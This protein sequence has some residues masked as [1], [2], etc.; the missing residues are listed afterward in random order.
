MP[1]L[2]GKPG[3]RLIDQQCYNN[4]WNINLVYHWHRKKKG[5][6]YIRSALSLSQIYFSLVGRYVYSLIWQDVNIARFRSPMV[7]FNA[8]T[9]L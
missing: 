6:L 2:K 9:A 4:P 5:T 3:V 7:E 1:Q 8:R